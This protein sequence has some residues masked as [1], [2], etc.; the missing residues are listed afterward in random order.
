[1]KDPD[2]FRTAI[3]AANIVPEEVQIN[4]IESRTNG[5]WTFMLTT[6]NYSQFVVEKERVDNWPDHVLIN[7]STARLQEAKN[8]LADH[9]EAIVEKLRG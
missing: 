3:R 5:D 2:V 8:T 7:R 6:S 4:V 9:L 1:M